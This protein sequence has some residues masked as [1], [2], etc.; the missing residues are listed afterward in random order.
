[1]V[2]ITFVLII[3]DILHLCRLYSE[4]ILVAV[5]DALAIGRNT[6]VTPI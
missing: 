4:S 5:L 3:L 2:A 1:M 6:G